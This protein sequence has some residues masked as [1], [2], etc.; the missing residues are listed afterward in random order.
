MAVEALEKLKSSINRGVTAINVKT[1]STLE[2]AK[3]KT[4]IETI[5]NEVQRMMTAVGEA[6]YLMWQKEDKDF[7]KLDQHLAV[8]KQR[9][10]EIAALEEAIAAIDQRNQQILGDGNTEVPVIAEAVA[11]ANAC[12]ACGTPYPEGAKFCRACGNKLIAE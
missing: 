12:A 5:Q 9:K 10:A 8:I 2:K 4:Q 1:S 7:S 3:L 6:V 11:P